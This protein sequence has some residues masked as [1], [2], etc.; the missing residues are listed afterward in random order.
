M[1]FAACLPVSYT[2]L[3]VYKRQGDVIEGSLRPSR[4]GDKRAGLAKITTVNGL[5]PEQIRNRPKFGDL[6]PVYPNE[7]LRMEHGKDSITGRA[8]DIVSPIGKGQRGLIVS[9]LLYTSGPTQ[10]VQRERLASSLFRFLAVDQTQCLL[11]FLF[12]PCD[13]ML[14]A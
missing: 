8:I 7:P 12:K 13:H 5:D 2:H 3:D 6:T 10:P 11:N 1:P 4:G 14:P 9:C